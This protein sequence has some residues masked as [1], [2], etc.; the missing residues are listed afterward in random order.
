MTDTSNR[1][2]TQ[3]Q[4]NMIQTIYAEAAQLMKQGV[5]NFKIEQHLTQRGVP[6]GDAR[7]VV[8]QLQQ[9]RSKAYRDEGIKQAA[10]GAVICI[11]GIAVT[12]GTYS[13]ASGGGTYVVAWGAIIFGGWR[14][15]RGLMFMGGN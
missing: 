7:T 4:K 5:S 11:I 13:A 8:I 1:Q 9:M 3:E 6:A 15:L 12:V 10:I 14:F 2:L